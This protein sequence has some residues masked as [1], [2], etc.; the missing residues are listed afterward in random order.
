MFAHTHILADAA[1]WMHV[2][3]VWVDRGH[4]CGPEGRKKYKS[5]N[6]NSPLLTLH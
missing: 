1:K 2:N 6:S 5:K 4:T 3:T